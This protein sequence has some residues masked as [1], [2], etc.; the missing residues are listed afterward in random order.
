MKY[1]S[2][3]I[4]CDSKAVCDISKHRNKRTDI[5]IEKLKRG[6]PVSFVI[7]ESF[8]ILKTCACTNGF[9][10]FSN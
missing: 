1:L 6:L 3:E 9:Q 4:D 7:N 2:N 10:L 5:L 8:F